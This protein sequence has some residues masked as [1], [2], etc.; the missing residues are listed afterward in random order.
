MRPIFF[1]VSPPIHCIWCNIP[2]PPHHVSD[3]ISI[4]GDLFGGDLFNQGGCSCCGGWGT[5]I[6]VHELFFFYPM[7]TKMDD[8]EDV[9]WQRGRI[10]IRR[11]FLW[12]RGRIGAVVAAVADKDGWWIDLTI[13]NDGKNTGD[14][15]RWWRQDNNNDG[16][17]RQW[18]MTV[19]TMDN[20]DDVTTG[21]WREDGQG[22][23][24]RA[25]AAIYLADSLN[26]LDSMF[27]LWFQ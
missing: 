12:W 9:Q 17:R 15:W 27:S 11:P 8:D 24:N 4:S 1:H 3:V 25:M 7:T 26:H 16:W 19:M 22:H 2:L 14:G 23:D 13:N 10:F 21:Q 6:F 5:C 18:T 20:D